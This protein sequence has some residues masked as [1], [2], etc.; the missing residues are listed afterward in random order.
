MSGQI[1]SKE[2]IRRTMRALQASLDSSAPDIKAADEAILRRVVELPVY[3]TAQTIFA[4]A[5][6]PGET[7]SWP[8]LRRILQDG[9][10]LVL[11]RVLSSDKMAA[12]EVHDFDVLVRSRYGIFEPANGARIVTPAEIDLAI[13]PCLSC[14]LFGHRLGLGKLPRRYLTERA[15][16]VAV[17]YHER[18]NP[19]IPSEPHMSRLLTESYALHVVSVL[20]VVSVVKLSLALGIC[21]DYDSIKNQSSNELSEVVLVAVNIHRAMIVAIRYG[22]N[23]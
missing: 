19:L 1:N 16:P 17:I 3:R 9:K 6:L 12:F 20:P 11:P 5:S 7:N 8:L 4:Y 14:D 10:R 21:N 15:Y 23:I 13:I 2:A 22:E 18:L